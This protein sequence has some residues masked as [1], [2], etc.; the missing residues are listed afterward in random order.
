MEVPRSVQHALELDKQSGNDMWSSK[1]QKE[2]ANVGVVF[3]ILESVE[4]VPLG[5]TKASG[6]L[7][8][9]VKVHFTRKARCVLDGQ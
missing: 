5:Y 9:D 3:N 1:I 7:I 4:K 6:H 2:M 8:F